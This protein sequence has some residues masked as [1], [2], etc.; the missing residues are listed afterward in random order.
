MELSSLA[1]RDELGAIAC[2]FG[3]LLDMDISL[4]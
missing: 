1:Q 3:W 4:L 2:I